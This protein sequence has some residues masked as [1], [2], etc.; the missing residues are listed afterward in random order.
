MEYIGKILLSTPLSLPTPSTLPRSLYTPLAL[1]LSH[2]LS[3]LFPLSPSLLPP[4]APLDLKRFVIE[5]SHHL[6]YT[7]SVKWYCSHQACD[8]Q[9]MLIIRYFIIDFRGCDDESL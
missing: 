6:L 9:Q 2:S 7:L 3:A 1:P 4:L 8:L 5:L